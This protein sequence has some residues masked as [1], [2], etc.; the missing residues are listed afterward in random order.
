MATENRTESGAGSAGVFPSDGVTLARF[1]RPTG[2]GTTLMVVSDPH[3]SATAHGTLKMYHRAKQR[4]QMAVADAHRLDVDAFVVAGDLTKAGTDRERAL[5]RDLLG[6][7]P[8]PTVTVPGNHDVTPAGETGFDSGEEFAT[9]QGASSYPQSHPLDSLVVRAFDTTAP[10][11]RS[12]RVGSETLQT[13]DGERIAAPQIAVMHHPLA[14]VPRPFRSE[15]AAVDY[16]VENPASTA[17]VLADSGIELVLTG[18]LHWP[19]ATDYRGLNVVGAPG[20]AS[21]PP[22][23]LLVHVGPAGTTVSLVPLAGA[24]GVAEA[25]EYALDDDLR[26]SLIQQAVRDGYFGEFPLVDQQTMAPADT[27]ILHSTGTPQ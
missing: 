27:S 15:L 3:L 14:A 11:A 19:Y 5:A 1:D 16:R 6:I 22:A 12:G 17:D 24:N 7:A 26:G 23:Y 18:H 25:Y 8:R 4:F 13:L 9:W 21:F 10:A 2:T 20:C